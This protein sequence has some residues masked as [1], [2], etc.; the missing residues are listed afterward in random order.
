MKKLWQKIRMPLANSLALKHGLA[1]LIW[2]M[3]RLTAGTNR[4][5]PEGHDA[6]AVISAEPNAIYALWHGQHLLAPAL[7]PKWMKTVALVS[8]SADAEINALVAQKFGIETARGS[9]GRADQQVMGKGGARALIKLKKAL[10]AGKGVCMIADIPGG[11][12]R[13]AGLGIVTLARISGRPIMPLAL[14]SSRRMVL[15]K[16]RDKTTINLPFGHICVIFGEPIY[17]PEDAEDELMEKIRV[18]V[19]E[20]MNAITAEA[21]QKV[22]GQT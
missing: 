5:M 1:W 22:D 7:M 17:V 9:G 3:M 11:K 10:N 14:A 16:T 20:A 19:T 21:Y 13:D 6:D 18:Q 12:P 4:L 8:R 15:K 2:A